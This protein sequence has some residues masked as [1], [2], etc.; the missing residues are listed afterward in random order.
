M[1]PWAAAGLLFFG[2]VGAV[3]LRPGGPTGR[4]RKLALAGAALGASICA[5]AEALPPSP[6]LHGWILP[7][8]VLLV[9]YWVSGALFVAPMPHAERILASLDRRLAVDRVAAASPRAAAELLEVAY[10]LVYPLIPA[11][12]AVHVL[13]DPMAN[14]DRFWTVVLV[15]D[16]ICFGFLP[17]I[18]TRPP[19]A[20]M[21]EAPW[22]S[23]TRRLNVALLGRTSIQANTFPSGH[24]AEALAGALLVAGGPWTAT[25]LIG[26]MAVL[27]SAA[28]VLG[29][30]HYAADVIAGWAVALAVWGSIVFL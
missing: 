2:Y 16:F 8:A 1:R 25:A 3:S 22:R 9:G 17:W 27:I 20:F 12:L 5:A 19:R 30:Y 23:S 24:A 11:A 26:A 18:Q 15:T 29:R 4:R 7:P 14:T 6:L 13:T 28:A 10:L 21:A